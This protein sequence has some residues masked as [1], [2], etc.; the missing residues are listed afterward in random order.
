VYRRLSVEW[1]ADPGRDATSA[2]VR[3]APL[4]WSEFRALCQAAEHRWG[5]FHCHGRSRRHD[6]ALMRRLVG[7][8]LAVAVPHGPEKDRYYVTELGLRTVEWNRRAP[9]ADNETAGIP[10]TASN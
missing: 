4:H 3:L 8:G 7:Y 1:V 5:R 6:R 9:E 10:A 2:R